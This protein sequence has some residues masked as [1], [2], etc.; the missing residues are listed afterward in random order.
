MKNKIENAIDAQKEEVQKNPLALII[1]QSHFLAEKL[2]KRKHKWKWDNELIKKSL[3]VAN[4][5]E[6]EIEQKEINDEIAKTAAICLNWL[7][8]LKEKK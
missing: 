1:W 2:Q 8:E 6:N 7:K 3:T 5:I 4:L